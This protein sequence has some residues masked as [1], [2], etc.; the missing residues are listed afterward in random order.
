MMFKLV[1]A[2]E[3]KD[4]IHCDFDN[5]NLGDQG[6]DHIVSAMKNNVKGDMRILKVSKN[7]LSIQASIRI[8]HVLKKRSNN[9]VPLNL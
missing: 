7:K 1:L 3:K 4:I 2:D 9:L 5:N 8:S 6:I